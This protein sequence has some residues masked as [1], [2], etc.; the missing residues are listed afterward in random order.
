MGS[1]AESLQQ[2]S[3]QSRLF[4]VLS[5]EHD[6]L[7]AAEVQAIL[8]SAGMGSGNV[9]R[10]YRL[11]TLDSSVM[12]LRFVSERSLM[13][14]SCGVE[15]GRCG[16]EEGEIRGL[17]ENLP[18]EE[19]TLNRSSFAVRSVRLGGVNKPIRRVGLEKDVGSM[20]KA[21]VPRLNVRLRD[22][23]VTFI[24]ILFG[25][26]FLIGLSSYSKPSG[27]IAPRRPRK[28]PI[29]HPSTMPP[30]I[31]RCMINL[32]RAT[33]GGTFADPF[34]GVGGIMIE[35]AVI[36][37]RV[38]GVDADVRMLRGARRNLSYFGLDSLG[39]LNGDARR[40]PFQPVDAIATDPPYGRG[41]STMG[42]KV[43]SL[44]EDF[45]MGV[46]SSLKR[47]RHLCISAPVEVGVEDYARDAGL[48]VRERHLARVHRSLT[49]QFVVIQNP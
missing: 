1:V 2:S 44:V 30:K 34:S 8:E 11:L 35:A 28:R 4:F 27:L 15:L 37:C 47:G 10:S 38:V 13:Y 24:C 42:S 7:P 18:L 43:A 32:A 25:D 49:R 12:G 45:L 41:S 46:K 9:E 6:S 26:S 48:R 17:V 5:G 39:F 29:F 22:P 36:G 23:E 16:A 21:I 19:L 31:A 40:M 33:P 20:V 14:D 3:Q